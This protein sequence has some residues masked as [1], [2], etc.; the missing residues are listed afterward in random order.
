LLH[1]YPEL[2]IGARRAVS[3][4]HR[5]EFADLIP[6]FVP[7]AEDLARGADVRAL[8]AKTVAIVPHRLA[9]AQESG[10]AAWI[11][12]RLIFDGSRLAERYWVVVS[13]KVPKAEPKLISREVYD[14]SGAIKRL[15]AE[16]KELTSEKR[17]RHAAQ[18]PDLKPDLRELVVLPL[19]LRTRGHVYPE[20]GFDPNASISDNSVNACIPYIDEESALKLFAAD[21]AENQGGRAFDIWY[22][23]FAEQG[24]R[25]IGFFTLLVACGAQPTTDQHF[26]ELLREHPDQPLLRYLALL[27]DSMFT[28]WQGLYGLVPGDELPDSFLG[29]LSVFRSLSVRWQGEHVTHHL[30]G[31]RPLERERALRFVRDNAGNPLGWCALTF[32][33]DRAGRDEPFLRQIADAWGLVAKE[34]AL[35]YPARYEQARCLNHAGETRTAQAKYQELFVETL[36]KGVL[37]PVD[38]GFRYGLSYEPSVENWPNLMRQTAEDCIHKKQRPVVVALAW[39]CRQLGDQPLAETLLDLSLKDVEAKERPETML[40]AIEYLCHVGDWDQAD[41][42]LQGLLQDKDLA[43]APLLWRLASHIAERRGQSVEA[44]KYLETAL[45]LEFP[46]LPEVVNLETIRADYGR[47]LT[48]YRWLADAVRALNVPPPDELLARTVRAADRW[49]ML[50]TEAANV[51][52]QAASILKLVGGS[53]GE[54][55]AWDYLTTPLALRP[56][57]SAPWLSLAQSLVREGRNELADRCYDAAFRAE[58]TNAQILWDRAQQLQRI[59]KVSE[60]REQMQLL[61]AGDWQPRFTWIKQ[62]AR[63]VMEGR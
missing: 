17:E 21:F 39:Q 47:L 8:D 11:E 37:P 56:N 35:K 27:Q 60:A 28:R 58:P 43:Q 61:A 33:Q 13:E 48:H 59:G 34:S 24:D 51:C 54:E 46:H 62:Q 26:N 25:R 16:E 40:A 31:Q 50:D 45:D 29:R 2:G 36:H 14:V 44:I 20:V 3:R 63:Q 19:P 42:L 18:A 6:D 32:L 10:P 1:L 41:H 4:F 7:P 12:E 52:D 15:D 30:L 22:H 49:R 23:R 55:L 57:E 38:S 5:A 9:S 53:Q